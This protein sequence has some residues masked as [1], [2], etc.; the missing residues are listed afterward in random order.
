MTQWTPI[1]DEAAFDQ[2]VLAGP[3]WTTRGSPRSFA[4]LHVSCAPRPAAATH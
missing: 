1:T 4:R 2:P 3:A